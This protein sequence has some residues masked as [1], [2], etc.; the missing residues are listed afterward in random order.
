M[1]RRLVVFGY[2]GVQLDAARS[3]RWEGWRPTL[4]ICRQDDLVVSRL[5]LIVDPKHASL[6]DVLV[7]DIATVSP[8]TEIR[9]HAL[10]LAN[11]WD[12]E[13]VYGSLHDLAST[14]PFDT[15]AEEYLVH[16]TTGTH[17]QQICLFLL[18]ESRHFPARLLQASPPAGRDPSRPGTI[19]VIDLDLSRYD[20]LATRFA[21]EHREDLSFLKSGIATRNAAFNALIE[22]LETVALAS[23]API[24]LAGPTGAGK[25]RLARRVH[26]LKKAR[27]A[28]T[29]PFV[30][31][32]CATLR[33][34]GAMSTLFGH[35]KG[36]FT[37]AMSDRPGL[38]R[39]ADG[40]ILFLDEIGELGL[41]EQA[42]LLQA[43]ETKRFLPVGSD[44]EVSSDFQLVAGSNRDLG[45][46]VRAGTFREDLLAR[47]DLWTFRLPGLAE[48]REDIEPNLE[49]ELARF[50]AATS[51]KVR[52]TTEARAAFVRFAVSPQATWR[53]NF[54]DLNAAI[55][56]MATLSPSGRIAESAVAEE[57]QR[58][59][60][61][62]AD[63]D[64]GPVDDLLREVAGAAIADALDPF[65]RVQLEL[66]ITTCRRSRSLSEAGRALFASS[67]ARRSSVNDADRL[68]KYLARHSLTWEAVRGS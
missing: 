12:F 40:G 52:F 15:E 34:D 24:L 14:Y 45:A 41:D 53:G 2:F 56:R 42:M 28:L 48:R 10:A 30:E 17:V 31:L 13:A 62:W 37:G 9:R 65:D 59:R 46:A 39:A 44:K 61:S 19:T 26:E 36:S 43:L 20:R 49:H 7:A 5:E 32:N 3:M 63:R 6:A 66:V 64:G 4:D 68:R 25:S 60:A 55:T 38:L 29:G 47:I 54:R 18:T 27:R 50:E 21:R 67:R 51:R 8:E 58:L 16:V 35:V 22:R 23:R 11:P 1:A 33:G 57:I